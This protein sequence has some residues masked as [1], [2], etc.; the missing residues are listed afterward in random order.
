MADNDFQQA[1][2]EIEDQLGELN[3]TE[4]E[5]ISETADDGE[6]V[7]GFVFQHG[8]Q[9]MS[10]YGTPDAK[11]FMVQYSFNILISLARRQAVA[12]AV[13]GAPDNTQNVEISITQEHMD[14]AREQVDEWLS[15]LDS[16]QVNELRFRLLELL[17]RSSCSYGLLS[18]GQDDIYGFQMQHKIFP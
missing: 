16:S 13:E 5:S 7:E 1:L 18:E 4:I 10:I 15:E 8:S 17:S 14:S 9:G 6:T 12:D 2:V 11:F 3:A